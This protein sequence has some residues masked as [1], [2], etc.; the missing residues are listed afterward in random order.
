LVN[1]EGLH[2]SQ[3]PAINTK[4]RGHKTLCNLKISKRDDATKLNNIPKKLRGE[5]K[6]IYTTYKVSSKPMN[7]KD[8]PVGK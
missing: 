2:H 3:P 5:S 4:Q 7:N 1:V 6:S 8:M